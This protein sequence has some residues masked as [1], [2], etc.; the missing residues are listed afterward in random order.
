MLNETYSGS[1]SILDLHA[2]YRAGTLHPVDVIERVYERIEKAD[3]RTWISLVPRQQAH[4]RAKE[5]EAKSRD[6]PLYG[7]PFAIKDNID[8]EGM[9]TTA[10]CPA[11]GYTAKATAPAVERLM[12]AGA[13]LIGKTNMDQ[14]ATGLVGVRSPYGVPPNPF[15]ARYVPG[16][17]SSGSAVAVADGFVSFSLGTDTAGSGRVPAAFCNIVGFKPTRGWFST[18][19]TV[20]ACRSL[21]CV[22]VMALTCADAVEVSKVAGGFDAEDPFS[23]HA[24]Q[25]VVAIESASS[26]RFGIPR[27]EQLQFFGNTETPMLFARACGDLEAIGGVAVS[28]DYTP[29]CAAGALLYG[30]PW[31]A[32][33]W[34]ALGSFVAAHPGA[35]HP[36][37][38]R[39]L[40][41][42]TEYSAA[43][44]FRVIYELASLQRQAESVWKEIDVLLLATA[45]THY[46][47][48]EIEADPI[49]L[50]SNLGY[51]TNFANL[52][53]CCGVA[54]PHSFTSS[55]LPFGV[56]LIAPAWR[57][58]L[59]LDLGARLHRSMGIRLGATKAGV[60][61]GGSDSNFVP[62]AVVG[63][64]LRGQPLNRELQLHGARFV[65]ACRTA[66]CYRLYALTSGPPQRPG[67]VRVASKGAAIEVEVWDLPVEAF[68][69]FTRSIPAP[70]AIGNVTL[71]S[72]ESVKGFVCEPIAVEGAQDITQLGGWRAFLQD[73]A[74]NCPPARIKRLKRR[75]GPESIRGT[76]GRY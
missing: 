19:G 36:V 39:V 50:N 1:L 33:R 48:S 71:E 32:E 38:R 24:P 2:Q 18:R 10:A 72:G 76:Q 15:D 64:H 74:M 52:L 40:E 56:S 55:G 37:T 13:I 75:S 8:V 41:G 45:G 69:K 28:I 30:G 9:V 53:D 35:L 20:P 5:L 61:I 63:A 65:R 67:L 11:F 51:Y 25:Q 7:V 22:S 58:G 54:V 66:K 73:V 70:L 31:V 68:G 23:R 62:M 4:A 49:E 14:F 46:T 17:S 27:E 59:V 16:G 47:V 57:D 6:L 60:S 26:F 12:V 42:S 44:A 34:A 3:S 43:D 21:D 29:F